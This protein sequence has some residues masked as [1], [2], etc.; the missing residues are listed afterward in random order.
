MRQVY[1]TNYCYLAVG[2]IDSSYPYEDY[3]ILGVPY[4]QQFIHQFSYGN[5]EG[6]ANKF[7]VTVS[8]NA[9]PGVEITNVTYTTMA[10]S[11]FSNDSTS[12]KMPT[13]EIIAFVVVSFILLVGFGTIGYF[14]FCRGPN[15]KR[16]AN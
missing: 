11:P 8:P 15:G 4:L 9:Y 5:R 10:D 1:G 3:F 6:T 14:C 2:M 12:D 16:Q 7:N 13:S